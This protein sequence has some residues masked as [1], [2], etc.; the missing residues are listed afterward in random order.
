MKWFN[1][2]FLKIADAVS[3]GMGTPTN[4]FFWVL[5]VLIWFILGASRQTL[6]QEG[7]FLPAWFT[8]NAWNFPLNT[9]TTLAELYIGFLVAAATNRAERKLRRLI[10]NM[11]ATIE[12]VEKI[13]KQQ[14][15]ILEILINYQEKEL[16]KVDKLF[17]EIRNLKN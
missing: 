2:K 15:K 17:E 4:I 7:K 5:A 16:N 12:A 3:F 11:K 14:N 10:E 8:S 1:E 9:I 6:F 13:N